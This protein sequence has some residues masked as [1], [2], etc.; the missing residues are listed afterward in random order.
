MVNISEREKMHFSFSCKHL[1][2]PQCSRRKIMLLELYFENHVSF[3]LDEKY[4]STR[5]VHAA[6]ENITH[7]DS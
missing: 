4:R 2:Y 5:L 7:R 3:L 1:N 6:L